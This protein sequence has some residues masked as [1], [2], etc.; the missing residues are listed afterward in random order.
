MPT[1]AAAARLSGKGGEVLIKEKLSLHDFAGHLL[2][3]PPVTRSPSDATPPS[4][5]RN[6]PLHMRESIRPP[7]DRPVASARQNEFAPLSQTTAAT[8]ARKSRGSVAKWETLR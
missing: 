3:N 4:R 1:T 8:L 7:E 6:A 5:S 2:A